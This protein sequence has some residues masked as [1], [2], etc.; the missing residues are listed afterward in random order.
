MFAD[1]SDLDIKSDLVAD[2][3]TRLTIERGMNPDSVELLEGN[4][5]ALGVS[6]EIEGLLGIATLFNLEG[7]GVNIVQSLNRLGSGPD[8]WASVHVLVPDGVLNIVATCGFLVVGIYSV[9]DVVE[10]SGIAP[11]ASNV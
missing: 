5:I 3:S 6:S 9:L 10:K 1:V 2:N 8:T 4:V 11:L 7:L